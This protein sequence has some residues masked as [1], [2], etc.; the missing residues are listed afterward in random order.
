MKQNVI[1][2][3]LTAVAVLLLVGFIENRFPPT[4]QAAIGSH[5][6]NLACASTCYA[7]GPKGKVA[8][9]RLDKIQYI[10]KLD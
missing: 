5:D 6:W 1:I 7:I 2:I 3:L 4:A 9:I 8:W 10:G